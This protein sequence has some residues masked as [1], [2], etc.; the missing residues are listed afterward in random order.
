[1]QVSVKDFNVS[2]KLG[3]NGIE[4]EVYS[5]GGEHLGDLIIGKAKLEWCEGKVRSGN[6]IQK[7]WDELIEFFK[8]T[9]E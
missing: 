4:L 3:N 6:G 7:N 8:S 1:M 9:N 5:N 2:M